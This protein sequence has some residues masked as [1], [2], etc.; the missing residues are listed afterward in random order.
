MCNKIQKSARGELTRSSLLILTAALFI[1]VGCAE[2]KYV[3]GPEGGALPSTS[4]DEAKTECATRFTTSGLCLSWYWEK[5]PTS[6]EAGRLIFKT[7]RLN[8]L[9]RTPIEI[10]T[11]TVAEVV[12]WMPSMGHG[13]TPTKTARVDVG[14][15]RSSEVFFIMPGE[16]E[17]KF[18]VRSDAGI[19]DEAKITLT[20]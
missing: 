11:A 14:T 19:I 12:L 10:D 5:V 8:T 20:L 7:Y 16:W 2:P 15:Y 17:I 3:N 6:S 18:H 4:S 1:F 9:D 13:S